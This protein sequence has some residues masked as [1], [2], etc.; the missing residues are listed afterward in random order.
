[1]ATINYQPILPLALDSDDR[2]INISDPLQNAK[3]KLR[4]LILTNPGEKI[5]L[6]DFGV[7]VY[8]FLFESEK[9]IIKYVNS[10]SD[11]ESIDAIS[12]Q[13]AMDSAIRGQV[14]KY[15]PDI[16]IREI[17]A[18]IE[19]QV[20]FLEIK[21]IFRQFIGDSLEMTISA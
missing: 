15:L 10:N 2:F 6:P 7:G 3:Q 4:M 1:M 11:L 13:D 20:L 16:T 14:A 12:I 5:M 8:K 21:Y 19:Q 18:R 17:N 9:G